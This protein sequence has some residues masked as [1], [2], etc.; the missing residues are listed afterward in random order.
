[1]TPKTIGKRFNALI[2]L[3]DKLAQKVARTG[4]RYTLEPMNP[5]ERR[6]IHSN[7]QDN[8]DVTTRSVGEDPYRKV[9]IEPKNSKSYYRKPYNKHSSFDSYMQS[10]ETEIEE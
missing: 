10:E 9:V 8:P 3:S 7:L 1:M 4:K 2:S 6:I 5:Y